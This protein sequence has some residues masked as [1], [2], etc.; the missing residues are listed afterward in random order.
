MSNFLQA[1][2]T[3]QESIVVCT[4]RTCDTWTS[5]CWKGFRSYALCPLKRLTKKITIE[6]KESFS[7]LYTLCALKGVF[8]SSSLCISQVYFEL[9]FSLKN[10]LLNNNNFLANENTHPNTRVIF[11]NTED[12]T[13]CLNELVLKVNI[14]GKISQ[15]P[16]SNI[17]IF[18]NLLLSIFKYKTFVYIIGPFY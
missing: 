12:K 5:T 8:F 2:S 4:L 13:N 16:Y 11:K 18:Y 9:F 15:F 14:G 6:V 3:I 7:E 10:I 17:S 1:Q